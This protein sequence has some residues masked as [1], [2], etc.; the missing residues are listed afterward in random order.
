[1][2]RKFWKS[3]VMG[4]LLMAGVGSMAMADFDSDVDVNNQVLEIETDESHDLVIMGVEGN[5][6][7]IHI[8]Q[9]D[10]DVYDEIPDVF[11][12]TEGEL[13][14]MAEEYRS[15]DRDLNDISRTNIRTF[16]GNDLIWV[17]GSYAL[18]L[19]AYGG[20]GDDLIYGGSGL[21]VLYGDDPYDSSAQGDDE[22]RGG[23]GGDNYM[24]GGP[25]NDRIYAGDSPLNYLVGEDGDDDLF[26]SL[27]MDY[28][29]GG[30][31]ED[32]LDGEYDGNLDF[33]NGGDDADIFRGRY[34]R[35]QANT[36]YFPIYRTIGRLRWIVGWRPVTTYSQIDL[37]LENIVD[38]D[39]NEGDVNQSQRI[40]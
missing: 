17:D 24:Y 15:E 8:L 5:E 16:G 4:L 28:M 11:Q 20:D 22:L 12:F 30:D 13:I 38:F 40:N 18:R 1:M 27:G 21:N 37:E 32:L 7:I 9:F 25:L 2:L 35:L 23:E 6:V 34:Y 33:M 19:N 29:F 39:A 36:I 26:G 3:M 14:A 31:G 10:P